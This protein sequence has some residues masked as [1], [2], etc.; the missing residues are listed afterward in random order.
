[1][2]PIYSALA[3]MLTARWLV[4]QD[5][6]G[7]TAV[8]LAAE[9]GHVKVRA[10]LSLC[11]PDMTPIG[12]STSSSACR[13]TVLQLMRAPAQPPL[14]WCLIIQDLHCHCI[15]L[16]PLQC[17]QH[18]DVPAL[19]SSFHH[20]KLP[21]ILHM[22]A[23]IPPDAQLD[24]CSSHILGPTQPYTGNLWVYLEI[25]PEV[26]LV[27]KFTKLKI[28]FYCTKK[29]EIV[30]TGTL[31]AVDESDND[32]KLKGI[33]KLKQVHGIGPS[34][35]I[36]HLINPTFTAVHEQVVAMVLDG[37]RN[38]ASKGLTAVHLAVQQGC[39]SLVADLLRLP[40]LA[41]DTRDADGLTALHWAAS[42]GACCPWACVDVSCSKSDARLKMP[43]A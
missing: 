2:I 17:L 29:N 18:S 36:H 5:R 42:K 24:A 35:A 38:S 25:M 14:T 41:P 12:C 7:R 40:G 27:S 32:P 30:K 10:P 8:Q 23:G 28:L 34:K 43:E 9:A 13:C 31:K 26:M 39:D 1:M 11:T 20:S 21:D 19:G 16:G 3:L 22:P 6:E 4:V 15:R 33:N 37:A